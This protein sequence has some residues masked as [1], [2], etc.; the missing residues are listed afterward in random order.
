[1]LKAES[2][3]HR[4]YYVLPAMI[5]Y[6]NMFLG[7]IAIFISNTTDMNKI[8][9]ACVLILLAA[10]TDKMDGFIARKLNMT[11]EF[12]RELDSLCDLVSFGLAP[13]IIGLNIHGNYLGLLEIAVSLLFIGTGIFRLAR[14]NIEKETCYIIGLPI[15]I[16]GGILV[17]KYIIDINYR[18]ME[19]SLNLSYEN[20]IITIILSFL[21][22]STFRVKKPNI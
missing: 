14:F 7:A 11:S 6:F 2:R 12:G 17:A 1:M 19:S 5:T 22:I 3:E 4:K 18:I 16:A 9:M 15:T 8:K 21:M 13:T 10:I 20:L